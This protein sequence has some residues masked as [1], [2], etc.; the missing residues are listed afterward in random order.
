[1]W[2]KKNTKKWESPKCETENGA[3]SLHDAA[4]S[5]DFLHLQSEVGNSDWQTILTKDYFYHRSCYREIC[6]ERVVT[7]VISNDAETVFEKLPTFIEEK[8]VVGVKHFE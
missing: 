8:V 6:K 7:P 1:M 3:R 2:K 5:F 4:L